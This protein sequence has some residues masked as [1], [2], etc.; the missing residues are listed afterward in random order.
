[1]HPN[2]FGLR[3]WSRYLRRIVLLGLTTAVLVPS[4]ATA[5]ST[6][7]ARPTLSQLEA[8][9]AA[10]AT[11]KMA[12]PLSDLVPQL[13]TNTALTT[14]VPMPSACYGSWPPTV[15]QPIPANAA[16]TCAWGDTSAKRSIFLIGDSQAAMWLPAFNALGQDLGWKILFLGKPSCAPWLNTSAYNNDGSSVWN[17]AA[18]KTFLRNEINFVNLTRPNVVIPVGVDVPT[19]GDYVTLQQ[20]EDAVLKT[21]QALRPSRAKI[22]LLGGFSY[23]S[24]D[25]GLPTPQ[26]CLT[27]HSSNL[28]ECEASPQQVATYPAIGG[29]DAA[30]KSYNVTVVPTLNLFCTKL[31]CPIFVKSPSGDHLI[32]FDSFHMDNVYSAW[33]SRA[34][35]TLIKPDLPAAK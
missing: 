23:V 5:S 31:K 32:Y 11:I 6:T 35:E 10:S 18:C 1:M 13:S 25:Q 17:N 27:I 4:V 9:I 28:P 22:L 19:K 14:M 34:L 29:G 24:S 12:P 33:I 20:Q 30:A 15:A 3:R 26:N 2:S 7:S 21:F 8:E 16:T